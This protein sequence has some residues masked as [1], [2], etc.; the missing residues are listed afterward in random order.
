MKTILITGASSGIGYQTAE[1]LAKAGN[2]V[3]GAARHVNAMD[4]LKKLGVIPIVMDVTSE[5][6]IKNGLQAII[7]K[8]GKIDIL[9]NGAGYGSF[10]AI[11]NVTIA[12]AK[13]QFDVNVFG[14][15]A[16]TKLVLPYMKKTTFW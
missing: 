7:Q 2:Q 15:T 3:F 11:E 12:E 14:L 8:A 6:S 9:I 16:L 13:R 5:S 10:G 4:P 1:L